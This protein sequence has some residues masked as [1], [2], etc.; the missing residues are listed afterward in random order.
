VNYQPHHAPGTPDMAET[1]PSCKRRPLMPPRP[2]AG[3]YFALGFANLCAPTWSSTLRPAAHPRHPSLRHRHRRPASSPRLRR[4][5]RI[6]PRHTVGWAQPTTVL[7]LLSSRHCPHAAPHE[8]QA[9]ARGVAPRPQ[10][11]P[12]LCNPFIFLATRAAP[13]HSIHS[14]WLLAQ[15]R[16][17]RGSK[18]LCPG[19]SSSLPSY[20]CRGRRKSLDRHGWKPDIA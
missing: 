13:K 19:H 18:G 1:G 4:R 2:D 9:K 20:L 5:P 15:P 16:K 17:E 14:E 3:T 10:Q 6:T 7:L 8:C 12:S 11:R